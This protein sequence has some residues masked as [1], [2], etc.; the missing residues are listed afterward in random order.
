MVFPY[1]LIKQAWAMKLKQ[2]HRLSSVIYRLIKV[3]KCKLDLA[4]DG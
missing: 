3:T 1:A 2:P 4:A